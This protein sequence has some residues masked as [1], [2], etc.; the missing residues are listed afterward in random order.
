MRKVL[1]YGSLREGH[2]NHSYFEESFGKE[3]FKCIGMRE[4]KGYDLYSLGSYPA[5][6]KS[7]DPES[8]VVMEEFEISEQAYDSVKRMEL[9]AGYHEVET[10]DGFV[11]YA[12]NRDMSNRQRVENG[13]WTKYKLSVA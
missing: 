13:D 4:I 3:N 2:Y 7:S 6:I 8:V 1:F 10:E 5:V 9:G 12:Q 11:F